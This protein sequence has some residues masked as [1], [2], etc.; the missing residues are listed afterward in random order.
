MRVDLVRLATVSSM[1]SAKNSSLVKNNNVAFVD[2][3]LMKMQNIPSFAFKAT[4]IDVQDEKNI[5]FEAYSHQNK[6][7]AKL[8]NMKFLAVLHDVHNDKFKTISRKPL[9]EGFLTIHKKE[10]ITCILH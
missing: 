4:L 10:V 6:A 5:N 2:N 7:M 8:E 1:N 9:E 3:S